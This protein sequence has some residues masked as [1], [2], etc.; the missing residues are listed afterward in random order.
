MVDPQQFRDLMAGVCAP[1]T[2]VTT[3]QDEQPYGATVSAFASL[4][5]TPPLVSVALDRRSGLLGR[6]L[7]TRRFGVN[8]LGQAQD[9][10]AMVFARRG[11]DR[12]GAAPWCVDHGLPRLL[13]AASWIV[14]DL[15][16]AVQGGDHLLLVGQVRAASR[17]DTAP[18]IY[19]N[20]VFGT[21]SG[22]ASRPRRPINDHVAAM[23]R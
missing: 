10:L 2:I 17:V 9:D 1:V 6:I 14:C 12:F 15:Q 7:A 18:L 21:H 23:A 5:L 13:E 8:V 19:S 16:E 4:S 22:F 20:R 11:E 3:M